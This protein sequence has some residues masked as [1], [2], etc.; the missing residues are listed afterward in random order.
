MEA[1]TMGRKRSHRDETRT[2]IISARLTHDTYEL[3][4]EHAERLGLTRAGYVEHLIEN[5]PLKIVRGQMDELSVPLINELKRIGN[6]LNQIAHARNAGSDIDP[7]HFHTVLA[8][9]IR[10][11]CR[12][13]M[14]RRHYAEAYTE[15]V[16]QARD[17]DARDPAMRGM[18]PPIIHANDNRDT[19]A[20]GRSDAAWQVARQEQPARRPATMAELIEQQFIPPVTQDAPQSHLP[21]SSTPRHL[22]SVPRH[23]SAPQSAWSKLLRRLHLRAS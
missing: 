3:I 1:Q 15:V 6:N 18:P 5:R 8:D 4:S 19:P 20:P 16:G 7:S 2:K 11:I 17:D 9:I 22:S 12:N 14:T 10:V 13:E 21:W 23:D